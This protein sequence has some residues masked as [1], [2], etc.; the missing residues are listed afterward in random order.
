VIEMSKKEKILAEALTLPE[1]QRAVL[2]DDLWF[3]LNEMTQEQID[4][5]WFKEIKRRWGEYERGEA[6]A[7]PMDQ[8]MREARQR[9]RQRRRRRA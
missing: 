1:K 5:V 6:K 9:L 4:R 2:A 7:L 3:S 8:V